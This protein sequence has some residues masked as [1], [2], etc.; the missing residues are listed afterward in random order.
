[1]L[2]VSNAQ[3]IFDLNLQDFGP[4]RSIDF[5]RNGKNVLIGSKRGHIA[6]L[7]WKQKDLICEFQTK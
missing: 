1:M 6:M 4:Y 3:S 7:D 2:G 5:T